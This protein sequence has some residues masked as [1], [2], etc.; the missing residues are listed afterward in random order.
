MCKSR[1]PSGRLL[2]RGLGGESMSEQMGWFTN[3][4][5]A[6]GYNKTVEIIIKKSA[7]IKKAKKFERSCKIFLRHVSGHFN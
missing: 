5:S 7:K 2:L 1:R 3:L 4:T 6:R